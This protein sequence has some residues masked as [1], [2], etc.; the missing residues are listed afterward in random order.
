MH[1]KLTAVLRRRLFSPFTN[2]TITWL[3]PF[4]SDI[5]AGELNVNLDM[6]YTYVHPILSKE[7]QERYWLEPYSKLTDSTN[8]VGPD[9]VLLNL[10][11]VGG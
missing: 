4:I 8:S 5:E 2:T 10:Q 7:A 9:L 1:S 6:Y 11:T 3:N